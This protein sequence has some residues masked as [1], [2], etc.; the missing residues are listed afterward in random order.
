[1]SLAVSF[2]WLLRQ[3]DVK[4]MFLHNSLMEE[5]YLTQPLRFIDPSCPN[6]VCKLHK[7]IYGLKQAPRAWFQRLS[8]F[9][10]QSGFVQSRIDTS[11]FTFHNGS[12][13][14]IFL[15]YVDDIVLMG[16]SPSLIQSFIRMLGLEFELKDLGK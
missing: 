11:M 2:G 7:A 4:N 3:L 12:A 10:I 6:F 9:L 8:T 14:F 15:L 16:N 1:M 5:V 13:I